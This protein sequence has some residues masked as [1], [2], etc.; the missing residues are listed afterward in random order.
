[1]WLDCARLGY[2][3]V[4]LLDKQL[5]WFLKNIGVASGQKQL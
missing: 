1:M 5:E 3:P 2:R 4:K